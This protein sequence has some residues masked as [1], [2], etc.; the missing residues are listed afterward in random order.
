M[1]IQSRMEEL[2]EGAVWL[3]QKWGYDNPE[4]KIMLTG[5]GSRLENIDLLLSRLSGH[6]AERAVVHRIQTSREEVLRTPEYMVA[7]GLL[8]CNNFKA[9]E[10]YAGIGK[11]LVAGIKGLF[12]I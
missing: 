5:G 4:D 7:L 8:R 11:K 6:P 3:L 12:G 10:V 1:V 9:G 2:L